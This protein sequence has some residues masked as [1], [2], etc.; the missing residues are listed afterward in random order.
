[1]ARYR[2]L[3][4]SM[5]AVG[6]YS[7]TVINAADI[8]DV[9]ATSHQALVGCAYG[10]QVLACPTVGLGGSSQPT[11]TI[12]TMLSVARLG[13]RVG[14]TGFTLMPIPSHGNGRAP[15]VD[16][17]LVFR[18]GNRV[19]VAA[20]A[21]LSSRL[22]AAV[23]ADAAAVVTDRFARWFW[24]TRYIVYLANPSEWRSWIAGSPGRNDILAYAASPSTSSEVVVVDMALMD[25]D[26]TPMD[27][28]LRHEFGHVVTVFGLAPNALRAY[29]LFMRA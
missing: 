19:T 18:S 12:Y 23:A 10:I 13:D 7:L 6:V 3:F 20:S 2:D 9:G 26:V 4:R 8:T 24:P 11:E 29:R 22:P 25:Q 16:A 27:S 1:V 14:I 17:K 5:R 21:G 15:W 28:L